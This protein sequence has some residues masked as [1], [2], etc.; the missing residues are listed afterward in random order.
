MKVAY[1]MLFHRDPMLLKRAIERLSSEDCGFFVHVDLKSD[2]APFSAITGDNISFCKQRIPVYWAE[3]STVEAMLL[4]AREALNSSA[5]YDYFVFLQ[6]SV[7]PLRSGGYIERFLENHRG[8]E[9]MDLVK[10]P[11]PGYPL[12]R[13]GTLSYPSRMPVRR[14]AARTLAKVGLLRRDFHKQLR[15]LEPYA[16]HGYGWALSRHACQYLTDFVT[17]NPYLVEY[18]QKTYA[19]DESFFQTILGNSPFRP[20]FHRNFVYADWSAKAA[21]PAMINE[22]HIKFFA[23]QEKVWVEDEWDSGEMLFARKFSDDRPDLLQQMDEMIEQKE[24]CLTHD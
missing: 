24:K 14:L 7:Y 4:L 3:F 20:H 12:S 1:L 6:G 23:A 21:H 17:A 22:E 15:G 13:I 2:I 18:F 16:G 5:N 11:A 8:W 9:F 19:P 10:M